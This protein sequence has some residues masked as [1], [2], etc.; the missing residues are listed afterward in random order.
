MF[1]SSGILARFKDYDEEAVHTQ[2][3]VER[4]TKRLKK[5]AFFA[6]NAALV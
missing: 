4:L 1:A 5:E 6:P 2:V 3:V